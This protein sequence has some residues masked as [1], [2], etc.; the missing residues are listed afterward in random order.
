MLA[1]LPDFASVLFET[2][3][4]MLGLRGGRGSGKSLSVA[5]ALI[6]RAA[7]E[8]LRILCAREVQE[9]I[10]DSVKR[11]LDDAIERLGLGEFFTSTLTEIRGANGSLFIF[12]GL[13]TN[14][15]SIKSMSG[16]DI[17]WVEEAQTVS[18]YS[19]DV[20]LPTVRKPGSQL[21][22]T[23]NPRTED[24][25]VEVLF[26]PDNLPPRSKVLNVNYDMNP[27]F[28]DV[29]R[30]QMEHMR[31]H[32]PEQYAHIFLGQ[33]EKRSDAQV[34]RN[35]SIA[36]CQPTPKDHMR[37]G[38]DWGYAQDPTVLVRCWLDEVGRTL[39][40]DHEAWAV[41]CDIVDLPELFAT[42][43]ESERW[44]I[45]ADSAR[46]E[47]IA[48]M[49]KHYSKHIFPSVKGA[50]SVKEGVE[51]LRGM[52]LVVHPR[53]VHVID[54]LAAYRYK[55]DKDTQRVLPDFEDKDNHTIDAL[56]YA[57]E[58]ARRAPAKKPASVRP[59]QTAHHWSR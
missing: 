3:W 43:P 14:V 53:C 5:T 31:E 22:F 30:E 23:W 16:I 57:C 7:R 10:R 52:R 58:S 20:L 32:D 55:V 36:D 37:F 24:S 49:R 12:A 45:V 59:V 40:I 42:V 51:W 33:F 48:H 28:P 4:R 11:D 6:L 56:R 46:P 8:P 25:P 47:T 15:S 35:W 13:R 9:S 50:N 1:Q 29:L 34:F 38:A 17:C 19:L 21:I 44:P 41:G 39:Y 26:H 54:E 18:R 2:D 27:W